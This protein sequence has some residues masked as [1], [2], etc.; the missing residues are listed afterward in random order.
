MVSQYTKFEVSKFT[1]YDAMKSAYHF[2]FDFNWNYVSI[3]N[4]FRDIAGY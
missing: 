3:F 1:H 4:R 2:L